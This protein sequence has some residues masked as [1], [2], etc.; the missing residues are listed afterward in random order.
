MKVNVICFCIVA[1]CSCFV[2]GGTRCGLNLLVGRMIA[3]FKKKN[4]LQ[5]GFIFN[6]HRGKKLHF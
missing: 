3:A 5:I 1:E 4:T 2:D 6:K